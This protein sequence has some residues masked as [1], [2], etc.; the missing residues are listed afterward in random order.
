MTRVGD[1]DLVSGHHLLPHE[2]RFA[3]FILGRQRNHRTPAIIRMEQNYGPEGIILMSAAIVSGLIGAVVGF[4]GLGLLFL[5]DD[6]GP[7][8][9]LGY[10]VITAGIVLEIP[11]IIRSIQGIYAGRRFRGDRP[12]VKRS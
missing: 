11:S 3:S 9:H 10:Y 2:R 5:S 12:F 4:I 7:L 8:L 1:S 6:S